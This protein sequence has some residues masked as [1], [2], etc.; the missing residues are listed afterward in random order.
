M[1]LLIFLMVLFIVTPASA[2]AIG[3]KPAVFPALSTA[4]ATLD[5]HAATDLPAMEP[6][7]RDFQQ[8]A[9]D[10]TINYFEYAP[11]TS[12]RQLTAPAAR[13]AQWATSCS[14]PRSTS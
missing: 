11:T 5:I 13:A 8:A 2:Q 4:T 1:R 7:L 9:P 14:P 3:G 10:I 12:T 6:L